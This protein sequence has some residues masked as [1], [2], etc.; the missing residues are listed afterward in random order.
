MNS[1]E[2][3]IPR[4]RILYRVGN[5]FKDQSGK[6]KG[7]SFLLYIDAR[8]AAEGLD[9]LYSPFGWSFNWTDKGD[10]SLGAIRGELSIKQYLAA[11]NIKDG[12]S[13][14]K[15]ATF[16]DIGY[17]NE[18]KYITN[19][20]KRTLQKEW[21]KDSISDALKRCA[22]QAGVGREL[23]TAPFI[24]LKSDFLRLIEND[25]KISSMPVTDEGE[26]HLQGHI[27]KWYDSLYKD[28]KY[29]KTN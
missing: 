12:N 26:K 21:L 19:S 25:T 14:Y 2:Y 27:N 16:S 15:S 7:A 3:K 24:Y 29:S 23:Y 18:Y 6:V 20:G 13:V 4:D 9:S 10:L 1:T 17:P 22:V 11:S 5:T 8:T 28:E